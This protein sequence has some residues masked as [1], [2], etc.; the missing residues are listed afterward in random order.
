M[1]AIIYAAGAGNRLGA[2]IHKGLVTVAGV[3]MI[4]Y[5][6]LRAARGNPQQIIVVTGH[7]A[8]ALRE[9]IG[10]D[11]RGIPVRYVH[12]D[13]Y[14]LRGNM[15]SL[16]A[17]RDYCTDDVFFTTSD[18]VCSLQ[19]IDAF[20]AAPPVNKILIDTNPQ[21]HTDPDPVKVTVEQERIVSVRKQIDGS[22]HG[23]AIGMYH[24][25]KKAMQQ[26]LDAIEARIAA[27]GIDT[28]LYWAIDDIMGDVHTVPVYCKGLPWF[29]VDTPEELRAAEQAVSNA[30]ADYLDV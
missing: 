5:A 8:D 27:G 21:Y 12:N 4:D 28:S 15:S 16:W 9:H 17:A 2:A 3:P 1:N 11:Y 19:D 29:D 13:H 24:F 6:L 25:S 14:Q 22:V 23:A 20:F 7:F 10:A 26:M 30:Q 18:L